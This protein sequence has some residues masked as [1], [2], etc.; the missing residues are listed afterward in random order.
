MS[1]RKGIGGHHAATSV[2]DEW[3][4]PLPII[5]SLGEFDL[6]PCSPINRPWNTAAKHYTVLDNG[7]MLP[8]EGRV[9]MNPPYGREMIHWLE[10]M[11]WHN[12]GIALTFA[13]TETVAFQ[14]FVF[15]HAMSMFFISGRLTFHTVDGS[16]AKYNGGAPSVLIAYGEENTDALADCIVGGRHVL[17]NA[18]PI[19]TIT[20]SPSWKNVV[21]IS[22]IKLNRSGSLNDIYSMVERIA[23]D[24]VLKNKH[25]KEKIRQKLQQYFVRVDKG[26]YT[27]E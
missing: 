24:K 14:T 27:F 18:M 3:L 11:A 4:T 5:R 2:T 10:K 23:P 21:S 17:I 9:W 7:L 12:N 13:R 8:W 15:P 6:D 25:Y 19:I 20:Q 26:R 1:I 16:P 22:M